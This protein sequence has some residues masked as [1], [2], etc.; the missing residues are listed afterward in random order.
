M[1]RSVT[2][3]WKSVRG[4]QEQFMTS[5]SSPIPF[6]IVGAVN[7]VACSAFT[8]MLSAAVIVQVVDFPERP[9]GGLHFCVAFLKDSKW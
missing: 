9:V 4:T 8:M 6:R 1:W 3:R 2:F 5:T 7:R